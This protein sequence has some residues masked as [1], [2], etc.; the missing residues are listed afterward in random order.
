MFGVRDLGIREWVSL[1][2]KLILSADSLNELTFEFSENPHIVPA[3]L[4]TRL[5]YPR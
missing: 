4:K 2:V 1:V 3:D 5:I